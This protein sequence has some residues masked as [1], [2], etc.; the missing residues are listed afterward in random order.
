MHQRGRSSAQ[1]RC[2]SR[3][4]LLRSPSMPARRGDAGLMFLAGAAPRDDVDLAQVLGADFAHV[5]MPLRIGEMP[6]KNL[7]VKLRLLDLPYGVDGGPAETQVE[8]ANPA[9]Q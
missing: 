1:I 7:P 9:E 3:H 2:I 6:F 8:P 4:N 5:V